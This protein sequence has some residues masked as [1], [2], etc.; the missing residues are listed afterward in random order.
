MLERSYFKSH[1]DGNV[2]WWGGK[3]TIHFIS[4][5]FTA[6]LAGEKK[7]VV[8]QNHPLKLVSLCIFKTQCE[9]V[10]WAFTKSSA[11]EINS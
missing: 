6:I 10:S 4:A 11:W 5:V 9:K 3:Q 2:K 8:Q 7:Q 1:K